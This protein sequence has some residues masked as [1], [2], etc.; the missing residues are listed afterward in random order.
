MAS[1]P[2]DKSRAVA[3]ALCIPL[4]VFGAHRFYVGKIGTGLLQL[5]TLGGMGLWW[6]YDLITIASGEFRDADGLRVRQWDPED[7]ALAHGVPQELL[8]EIESLRHEVSE[9][10]ERVDFTERLLADPARRN[11]PPPPAAR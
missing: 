7:A 8:D 10:A 1:A 5:C 11:A 4:G 3:L 9:L 2:S 6:L